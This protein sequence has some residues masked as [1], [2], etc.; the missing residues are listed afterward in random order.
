MSVGWISARWP[1]NSVYKTMPLAEFF[2]TDAVINQGNSGGPRRRRRHRGTAKKLLLEQRSFWSGLEGRL[3]TN[4]QADL[5][6]LPPTLLGY[7][8]TKWRRARRVK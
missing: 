4:E 1:P 3:L 7:L 8:V 6:N 2:Q 5:F